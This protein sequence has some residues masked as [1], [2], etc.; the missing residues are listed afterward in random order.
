MQNDDELARLKSDRTWKYARLRD[1]QEHTQIIRLGRQIDEI[2]KRIEALSN[3][4]P[5]T[6][7]GAG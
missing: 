1:S 6:S 3:K 5:A 4:K 7:E 2:D